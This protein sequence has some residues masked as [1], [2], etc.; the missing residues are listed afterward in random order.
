MSTPIEPRKWIARTLSPQDAGN[1]STHGRAGVVEDSKRAPGQGP[2]PIA[3]DHMY[4]THTEDAQ[5][6]MA[7]F[8][9]GYARALN[10]H[11]RVVACRPAKH[12]LRSPSWARI[13]QTIQATRCEPLSM[14]EMR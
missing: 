9:R 11:A 1:G 12:K 6:I 14:R 13:L 8:S 4:F 2:A 10:D 3:L 7:A 5:T